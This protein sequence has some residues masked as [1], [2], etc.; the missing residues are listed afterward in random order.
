MASTTFGIREI[1]ASEA[2]A[3]WSELLTDIERGETVIVMRQGKPIA[4]ILPEEDA[5]KIER[6]AAIARI[7][8]RMGSKRVNVDEIISSIHEGHGV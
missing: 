4:R 6:V 1:Q 3:K 7:R 8:A 2:K 5:K